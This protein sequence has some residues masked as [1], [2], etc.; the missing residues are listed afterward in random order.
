M[1]FYNLIRLTAIRAAE[2]EMFMNEAGWLEVIQAEIAEAPEEMLVLVEKNLAS[3][4]DQLYLESGRR[5][6]RSLEDAEYHKLVRQG[7]FGTRIEVSLLM[8]VRFAMATRFGW[9]TA[10]QLL[11]K[12]QS[13]RIA[14]VAKMSDR[15]KMAVQEELNQLSTAVGAEVDEMLA[16]V[17]MLRET[18]KLYDDVAGL[19]MKI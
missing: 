5:H 11:E 13:E 1:P 9:T 14:W 15:A 18:A 8:P 2:L 19:L 4:V 12:R 10:H 3:L 7:M 16:Q 17:A 6:D